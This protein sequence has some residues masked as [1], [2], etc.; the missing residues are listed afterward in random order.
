MVCCSLH[1]LIYI[2]IYYNTTGNQLYVWDG[3]NW[4]AAAFSSASALVASNNLSDV[5]SVATARTNLDVD[6]AGTALAMAIA[7]G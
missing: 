6:Q 7:L 4:D 1:L 2:S 3:S 5:A